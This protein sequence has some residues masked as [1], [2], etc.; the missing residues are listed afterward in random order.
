MF[1]AGIILLPRE[2]HL[3]HHDPIS[4]MRSEYYTNYQFILILIQLQDHHNERHL[5]RFDL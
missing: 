4:P 3:P 1:R 5:L 2:R